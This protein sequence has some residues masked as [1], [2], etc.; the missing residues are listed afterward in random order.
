MNRKK[1]IKQLMSIGVQRNDAVA[2]ARVYRKVKAAKREK[3]FPLLV[4]P[5]IPIKVVH[6]D[7]QRRYLRTAVLIPDLRLRRVAASGADMKQ[8]VGMQ[9]ANQMV[10]QLYLSGLVEMEYRKVP[11][12]GEGATEFT[13]T[14]CVLV[15]Q[16]IATG[17]KALAM[18]RKGA[19]LK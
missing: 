18:T 16:E 11:G 3:L 10:D 15:P 7:Y 13:A 1:Q 19:V 8:F 14:V 9:L 5:D 4:E 2:F 12:Y 6:E 17:L